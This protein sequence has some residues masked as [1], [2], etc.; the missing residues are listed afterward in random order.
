MNSIDKGS[1]PLEA[2]KHIDPTGLGCQEWLTVSMGLKEAGRLASFWE[3]W[4]HR[5]SAC[6]HASE[7]LWK[8]G[9]F[10]G[11]SGGTP[12]VAGTVLKM[13]LDR[14]RRPAQGNASSYMLDWEDTINTRDGDG[15]T[16]DHAWLEGKE[17]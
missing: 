1:D 17:V 3:D 6:Y 12:M 14:G 10:R 2:L 8:W 15:T 9:A 4:S 11:A 7:C 5:D 13:A 16:V